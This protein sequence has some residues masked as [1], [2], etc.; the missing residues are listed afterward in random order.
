MK[1]GEIIEAGRR[2]RL[3]NM[4]GEPYTEELLRATVDLR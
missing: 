3:M 2:E 4:P 1:H